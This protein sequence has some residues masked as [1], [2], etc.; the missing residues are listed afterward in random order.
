MELKTMLDIRRS[1]LG[2]DIGAGYIKAVELEYGSKGPVIVSA[3]IS[4]L[5]KDNSSETVSGALADLVEQKGFR[6]KRVAATVPAVGEGI[7]TSRR[8]F[9]ENLTPDIKKSDLKERVEW[10]AMTRDYFPFPA[11]EAI[12]DCHILEEATQESV[13]GIWV[14]LVAVHRDFVKERVDML[15]SV[16]LIPVAMEIDFTASL[17]FLDYLGLFPDD[18]DVVVIDIGAEKTSIGIIYRHQLAFYRDISVAGNDITS[19]IERRLRIGRQEAEEYKTTEDLFEKI[20]D[21]SDEIWRAASPI[22]SVIEERQG[23]YPQILEC[24]RYYEGDVA[25]AKL[26]KIFFLGGTSQLRSLD[27]FISHRLA[28]PV[29]SVHFLDYVPAA[30]EGEASEIEGM[31]PIFATATGLA[32]K[33]FRKKLRA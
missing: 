1:S 31:E 17:N 16:G 24:L 3:G 7:A 15:R 13:P 22:E 29:E 2:V 9:M 8:I 25:N 5:L 32:L 28:I 23:L 30:S 14:F 20:S 10:E 4:N 11:E 6:S 19:Q 21:G 27:N 12:V 18:E 26:S 33:P